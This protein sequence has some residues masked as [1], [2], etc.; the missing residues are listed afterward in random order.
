[1]KANVLGIVAV[2]SV[3]L[4]MNTAVRAAEPS[5]LRV[6]YIGFDP[7]TVTLTVNERMSIGKYTDRALEMK[8]A[9]TPAFEQFLRQYFKT[10]KVVY[11][12]DYREAMSAGYDVT[13][14]DATPNSIK[15]QII[16]RN[17]DTG[18]VTHYQPRQYLTAQFSDAALLIS[19]VAPRIA[20]PL[21]Y[22][23]DWLCE[24]LDA[25]AH[26][27]RLDHPIFNTPYPVTLTIEY[28]PTP[29]N[30]REYYGRDG[31]PP[32]M[33]MWRVQ[34]EGYGDGKGFP[35]GLVSTGPGF[36]D[37]KDAEVI[38]N[39][40]CQ[41]AID[42]VALGRHGNFFLWGFSADPQQMTPEARLVFVNAVHYIARFKGQLPYSHRPY[43][44]MTREHA[45]DAAKFLS[46]QN[47]EDW[48]KL[49]SAEE[50]SRK[51][52][53][54]LMQKAGQKLSAED[55]KA[56]NAPDSPPPDRAQWLKEIM[57]S[58]PDTIVALLGENL[59]KY[60]PYYEQNLEYLRPGPKPYSYSF[61]VDE[62]IRS[63]AISNRSVQMLEL[64]V[65]MLDS[66]LDIEKASRLLSRYT[67]QT[68]QS[69]Q[70][71]REWLQ[72]NRARLYFSDIDGF[73]F[74]VA[75]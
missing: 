45:L 36:A 33:P 3:I 59:G 75:P 64:C 63:L 10:V 26:G 53:F 73:R 31:L 62:D 70:E 5:A 13:I 7:K 74:H 28:R 54:R 71:W 20:E 37:A 25:H 16:E 19:T 49:H 41:K 27:M 58:Q 55:L 47:Y 60:L 43:R 56:L 52:Y 29:A 23:I 67:G 11:A 44:A 14:F 22:K 1:M 46:H 12:S 21:E 6:L 30:Y 34:T 35:A 32:T 15:D 2:L 57:S 51:N 42:S 48:V 61:E 4:G 50:E 69:A 8:K 39:G 40:V 24:C 68:F 66:H 65:A 72:H 9:R 17:P 18:E 38:S